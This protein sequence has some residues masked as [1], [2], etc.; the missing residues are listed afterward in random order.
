MLHHFF[1][2]SEKLPEGLGFKVKRHV[3]AKRM[4]LRINAMG[5]VV[6]TAPKFVSIKALQAFVHRHQSWIDQQ[7]QKRPL[8]HKVSHGSTLMLKGD[9]F[10]IAPK[11]T[12]RGAIEWDQKTIFIPGDAASVSRRLKKFLK[13]QALDAL[14]SACEDHCKTL[15]KVCPPITLK[16]TKSRWGSCARSGGLMFS[17]RLVMAPMSVLKYVAAHEVA[18]LVHFDHSKAFWDLVEMLD[19][20]HKQSQSWLKQNGHKLHAHIFD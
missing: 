14:K 3:A 13:Q 20:N 9:V 6:V 12:L 10:T 11:G 15:G 19:P 2:K 4:I 8:P 16:D 1:S 5:E 17:W 18:H 7:A